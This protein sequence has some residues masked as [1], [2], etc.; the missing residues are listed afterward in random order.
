MLLG[1]KLRIYCDNRNVIYMEI[2]QG[3][4]L[5]RMASQI[6]EYSPEIIQISGKNNQVADLLSRIYE[7]NDCLPE[8]EFAIS[9]FPLS[10]QY[11]SDKQHND[12]ILI[13]YIKSLQDDNFKSQQ[14]NNKRNFNFF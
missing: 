7:T 2:C 8:Q 11:I 9:D 13:K 14:L 5:Q 10:Y 12:P 4:Q 3:K 6:S 1:Q